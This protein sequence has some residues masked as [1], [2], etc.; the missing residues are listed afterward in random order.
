MRTRTLFPGLVAVVCLAAFGCSSVTD[1]SGEASADVKSESL[2][3]HASADA[4]PDFK[5]DT[6]LVPAASS[7][8]VQMKLSAAGGLSIDA[9]GI[10]QDGKIAGK[11]G[12]GKAKI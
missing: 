6:G 4:L 11:P 3:F 8:Q 2:A 10:R 7:A 12:S 5:F 1:G 9:E